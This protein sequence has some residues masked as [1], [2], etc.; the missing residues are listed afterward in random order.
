MWMELKYDYIHSHFTVQGYVLWCFFNEMY[1]I[2]GKTL[3]LIR[4][5]IVI[6]LVSL[7]CWQFCLL[8]GL[9]SVDNEMHESIMKE[10]VACT[11]QLNWLASW[12]PLHAR[13]V[14]CSTLGITQY[15]VLAGRVVYLLSSM[16]KNFLALIVSNIF[17]SS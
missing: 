9:T 16:Y 3:L 12:E 8:Y 15:T 10:K 11:R 6:V 13:E 17:L 5:T 2:C 1:C 14:S 4:L 7:W